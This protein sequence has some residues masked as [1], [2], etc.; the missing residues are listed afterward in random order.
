LII[1]ILVLKYHRFQCI[2]KYF[3]PTLITYSFFKPKKD[4][5]AACDRYKTAIIENKIELEQSNNEHLDR[6]HQS[7]IAK[8]I[9]NTLTK[10]TSN[11]VVASFDL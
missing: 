3:S 5:C 1:P 8:D 7:F 10:I 11:Y 9:D 4:Q 2:E 6:M